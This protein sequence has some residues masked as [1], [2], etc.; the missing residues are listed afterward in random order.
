MAFT[1]EHWAKV[2]KAIW[3]KASEAGPTFFRSG[4]PDYDALLKIIR[5]NWDLFG[6]EKK[7]DTYI[8]AQE[9][10]ALQAKKADQEACLACTE[11]E[12]KKLED[13]RTPERRGIG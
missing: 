9:L 7:L 6:N 1:D 4:I 13:A 11:A 12:I 8:A 10:A 2:E 3:F 5:R